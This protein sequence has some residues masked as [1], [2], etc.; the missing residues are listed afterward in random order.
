ML[1]SVYKFN[2]ISKIERYRYQTQKNIVAS[3]V[4]FDTKALDG[5]ATR[6]IQQE[7]KQR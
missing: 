4:A 6:A 5:L 1:F 3:G 2:L 7:R